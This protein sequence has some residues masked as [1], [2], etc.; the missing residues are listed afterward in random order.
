MPIYDYIIIGAGSA[1]CVLANRLSADGRHRVALL[2][3]GGPDRS[4]NI[5]IPAAFSKLMRSDY[6]WN[7][8]TLPQS[9]LNGRQLYQPRGKGLGGSS[10]INAMI[11][12]RG[13]RADY[14]SWAAAGNPGWSYDEVLPYFK[15][16]EKQLFFT[17]DPLHATDGELPVSSRSD[18][19]PLS[20]VFLQAAQEQ[21]FP[22]NKDFNGPRQEGF[23]F[24]QVT[25]FNGE[26]WSAARTWLD[27]ARGRSNLDILTHSQAL[28]IR[29]TDKKAQGVLIERRGRVE[30]IRAQ[31]EIILS[32]GAINSPQLLL[33]SGLGDGT[34]LQTLGIPMV[35]HLPGVGKNLQDHLS[36][37]VCFRTNRK[38]TLDA[39]ERFPA[40][41]HNLWQYFRHKRGPF[42]SN[43]A[44]AAGFVRTQPELIA[45][46][47]QFHFGPLFF[48]D[49]GFERPPGNGFSLGPQ[50][51]QPKSRGEVKLASA[52]G[53]DA[54]L[55]DPRYL[56][57]PDDIDLLA[58]GL[59][60]AQRI[61][62]SEA[63]SP[64]RLAHFL[65]EK[66]LKDKDEI[67]DY[68][69]RSAEILYHPVGTCKMGK[70]EQAVVDAQ[71]R[72]HDVEG[73]RVI[74]ASIMPTICRGNTNA[75]TYMIAEK[76]ADLILKRSGR[77]QQ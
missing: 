59:R 8:H 32:A 49:H 56:S 66:T 21:G 63:F 23:G 7:Y 43:V 37:L 62:L 46:D 54:A 50:L 6:D 28:K 29:F 38:D 27:P 5:R 18:Q 31:K 53:K 77:P 1:G 17:D 45:P 65:P 11:Y 68:I 35:H 13:H 71:L 30:E 44:E 67:V 2:E 39:A 40:L 36:V 48:I 12:I 57:H 60:I 51:L 70:D 76:G 16:S 33:L 9:H 75:P 72:V 69:R 24:F 55:I 64:Y 34:S 19:H 52:N 26:R 20:H 22:I 58:K 14:N 41:L 73:L 47:L 61:G 74:D 25:Q 4:P 3:A 15:R 42:T 10:S